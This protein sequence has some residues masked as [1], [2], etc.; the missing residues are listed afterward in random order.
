MPIT[1]DP[2]ET[3]APPC[4]LF[5]YLENHEPGVLYAVIDRINSQQ[6]VTNDHLVAAL[7]ELTGKSVNELEEVY[8]SFSRGWPV[9]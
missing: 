1:L 3:Y 8:L 5:N 4:M 6:I 9:P 7:L 2:R